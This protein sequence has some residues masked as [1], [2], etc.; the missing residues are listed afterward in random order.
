MYSIHCVHRNRVTCTVYTVYIVI[1]RTLC[2]MHNQ[3]VHKITVFNV[4]C[5]FYRRILYSFFDKIIGAWT[6]NHKGWFTTW[7]FRT[8]LAKS[9]NIEQ[10]DKKLSKTQAY[11]MFP[12]RVFRFHNVHLTKGDSCWL[13]DVDVFRTAIR[14]VYVHLALRRCYVQSESLKVGLILLLPSFANNRIFI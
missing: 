14:C 10:N 3:W 5:T 13:I 2:T 11:L 8:F 4:K 9:R 1:R 6:T 7:I 12:F